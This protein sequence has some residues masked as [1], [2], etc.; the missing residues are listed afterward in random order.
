MAIGT[1]MGATVSS[2]A[3]TPIITT[4]VDMIVTRPN[5]TAV[6]CEPA[7]DPGP[8]HPIGE[9][10]A[11]VGFQ[12]HLGRHVEDLVHRSAL[13]L[14]AERDAQLGS[15]GLAR[16]AEQQQHAEEHQSGGK[17]TGVR[18]GRCRRADPGGYGRRAAVRRSRRT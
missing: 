18:P 4:T 14:L 11:L 8:P 7:D 12:T 16:R 3:M 15:D 6:D 5:T 13:H 17:F 9:V 2:T 1:R 10:G